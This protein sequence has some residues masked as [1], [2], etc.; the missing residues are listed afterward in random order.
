VNDWDDVPS[1]GAGENVR[2]RWLAGTGAELVLVEIKAGT[3]AREHN[4]P[5]EQFVQVVAGEGVLE[6][7]SGTREFGSG[8][9]FHSPPQAWHA[10]HFLTDT[11]LDET[12]LPER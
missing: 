1:E 9:V 4:H 11:V 5:R 6:T 3:R 2:K 10:A 8:S 12:N 7:A